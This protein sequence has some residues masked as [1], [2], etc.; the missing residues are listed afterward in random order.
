MAPYEL[1]ISDL[2]K[3]GKNNLEITFLGNNRNLLGPH[4]HFK[5]ENNYVGPN[6]FKGFYGYEDKIVNPDVTVND[7]WT[8]RYSFV[9]FGC[10][11]IYIIEKE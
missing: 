3:E 6:T 10:G 7:T 9:A 5:G 11:N 2:L 8:D 4:H 1:E